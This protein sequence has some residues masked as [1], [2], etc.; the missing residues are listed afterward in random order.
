MK[1]Y[2]C[3]VM[4]DAKSSRF[5]VHGDCNH[6]WA[7]LKP[8]HHRTPLKGDKWC[9]FL[10]AET[11]KKKE[12]GTKL[13]IETEGNKHLI[14][15]LLKTFSSFLQ[16]HIQWMYGEVYLVEPPR[17]AKKKLIVLWR[18]EN[19]FTPVIVME[20]CGPTRRENYKSCLFTIMT[21]Q[22]VSPPFERPPQS[23][24]SPWIEDHWVQGHHEFFPNSD[25]NN[26][27][28]SN[29]SMLFD[30]LTWAMLVRSNK[31]AGVW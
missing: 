2:K 19:R 28:Q 15:F 12:N 4:K 22:K 29:H 11:A 26:P 23:S 25:E 20:L 14:P 10:K 6:I 17:Y 13:R 30:G 8:A 5:G 9:N 16:G 7:V 27:I 24:L 3:K 18:K 21:F 1:Q 31:M